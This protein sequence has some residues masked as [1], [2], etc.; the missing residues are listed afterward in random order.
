MAPQAIEIARNGLRNG[1]R[2][3][4][5][6]RVNPALRRA[7]EIGITSAI[8]WSA[9]ARNRGVAGE[10]VRE[11]FASDGGDHVRR[12]PGPREYI[13]KAVRSR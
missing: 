8:P 7:A 3:I 1:A 11:D 9:E 2:P 12:I 5:L 13:R 4:R 6:Y 10:V